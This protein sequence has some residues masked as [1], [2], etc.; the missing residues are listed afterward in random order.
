[1]KIGD[2]VE[3]ARKN[4]KRQAEPDST[5]KFG[6]VFDGKDFAVIDKPAGL[7]VHQS[8]THK[9]TLVNGLLARWP[10]IR[11]GDPSTSSGQRI[12]GLESFTGW[13]RKLQG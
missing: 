5:I 2:V 9:G 8:H 11:V 13:I 1:M 3:G 6:I 7:V 4:R 10:E 12:Y